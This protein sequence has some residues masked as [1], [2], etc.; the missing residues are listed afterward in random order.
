MRG[1]VF[2]VGASVKITGFAVGAVV[3]GW[4][5]ARSV[6]AALLLAAVLCA[7]SALP[8]AGARGRAGQRDAREAT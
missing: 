7:V 8:Y 2:A 1:R 4:V 5:A 3:A 6:P